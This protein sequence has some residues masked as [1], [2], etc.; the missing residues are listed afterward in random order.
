MSIGTNI[1]RYRKSKGF[2]QDELGQRIGVTNQAVSKWESGTTMP[3]VML[4]PIIARELGTTID[5]LFKADTPQTAHSESPVFDMDGVHSFPKDAQAII[6]D[7]LYRQTNLLNCGSWEQLKTPQNPE[8]KKYDRVKPFT[9]LC[10]ISEK[11]G[12]AFVSD[13]L[14]LIDTRTAASDTGEVF[15]KA[16]IAYAMKKLADTNVRKVLACICDSYFHSTAPFEC[17]E[18]FETDVNP[19]ELSRSAGLTDDE[20]IEALE[21]LVSLHIIDVQMK[22]DG[23][24][25]MFARIKAL[26]TA[27]AFRLIERMMHNQPGFCCGDIMSLIQV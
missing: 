16:E 23:A 7:T 27:A 19:A 1:A 8:T 10:C 22:D 24:H 2:T 5:D 13:D 12:S 15:K 25:Y 4:L 18:Y 6:I 9:T 21:K 11:D 26:E 3:D 14:T 17:Y 20:T